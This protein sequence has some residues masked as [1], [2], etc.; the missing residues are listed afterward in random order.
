MLT[1]LENILEPFERMA[2]VSNPVMPV[3]FYDEEGV[4]RCGKCGTPK[5]VIIPVEEGEK[6]VRC[7]CRCGEER[8]R[9]ER[10]RMIAQQNEELRRLWLAGYENMTFEK[11][12]GNPT[13][14][15]AE[16]Y[17]E[18]WREILKTRASFTLSG[19]VGCG[20]TYASAAIANAIAD[21]GYRVWMARSTDMLDKM[22]SE[23]DV[24]LSRLK[25]FELVVIDDF[26][27]ERDTEYAA[28]KIYD[29]IDTRAR[30]ELPTILTTNLDMEAAPPSLAYERIYS[31]IRG[32]A[33][34]FRCKGEDMR[35]ARGEERRTLLKELMR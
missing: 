5:E 31:R 19:G 23:A 26:G 6:K 11:S 13:M 18:K 22:F 30:A 12:T 10:T 25:Y 16:K 1:K 28:Q 32:F 24:V 14:R 29:I 8:R 7:L 21:K 15:F 2:E 9:E 4:L 33:P 34:Q 35:R 20:K 17:V 3:D 27:A